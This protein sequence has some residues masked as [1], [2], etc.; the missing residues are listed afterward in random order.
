MLRQLLK[1]IHGSR[2]YLAP[3]VLHRLGQVHLVEQH[4]TQLLGRIDVEAMARALENLFAHAM[5]L[6]REPVRHHGEH[7]TI[8]AHAGLFHPQQDR[9][10]GQIDI[11]I[12]LSGAQR[13]YVPFEHR[14]EGMDGVRRCRQQ[15]HPPAAATP[16]W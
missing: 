12:H 2:N 11:A 10:Q 9:H 14:R 16:G 5:H 7:R 6:H 3:A 8:D 13:L 1:H 15:C 4:I